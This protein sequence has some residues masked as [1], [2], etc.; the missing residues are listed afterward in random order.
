MS[1]TTILEDIDVEINHFN[2]AFPDVLNNQNCLYYNV[3]TFNSK[4]NDLNQTD[5]S[6]I[7]LNIRSLAANGD[8]F[9]SY[10][11]MLNLNFDVICFSETWIN[12]SNLS[13]NHLFPLYNGYHS[14]RPPGK[15]GGGVSIF[16]LKTRQSKKLSSL[17]TNDESIECVFISL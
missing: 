8:D 10:I 16:V 4:F 15:R 9:N 5:L 11:S 17:S 14:S 13:D 2:N 6:I 7:H 1:T 3:E 12:E